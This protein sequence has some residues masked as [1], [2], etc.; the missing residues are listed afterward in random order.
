MILGIDLYLEDRRK[1]KR[2]SFFHPKQ[3][4]V[5]KRHISSKTKKKSAMEH[6]L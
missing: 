5:F 1:K 3:K 2:E 4:Q 6:L